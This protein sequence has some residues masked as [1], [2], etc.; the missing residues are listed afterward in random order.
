MQEKIEKFVLG[1]IA[2]LSVAISLGDLL[3]VLDT[4]PW[5]VGRTSA[6]TLLVVGFLAGYLV[7]ERRSKLDKIERL[8]VEGVERTIVSL[9]GVETQAFTNPQ[10]MYEYVRKRMWEAQESIDDLSWGQKTATSKMPLHEQALKKY[11]EAIPKICSKKKIRYREVMIFS[12]ME[13]LQR[14]EAMVAQDLQGY[15]L[16]YYDIPHQQMPPLLSFMLIDSAEVIIAFYRPPYEDERRLA[17][18]HPGIVRL[19]QDY[20]NVIWH[21]AKVIKEADRV[22]H[23]AFQE[24]RQRLGAG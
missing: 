7:L 9:N 20:Y 4:I 21:R 3:G 5:L 11:I 15:R 17:V 12:T 8:V 1:T 14:A 6:L 23:G 16:R 24:I 10:E 18:K 13:R 22:E 2:V 19:F